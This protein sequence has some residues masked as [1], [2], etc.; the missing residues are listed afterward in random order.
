MV[1]FGI[2]YRRQ[3]ASE[4]IA[5]HNEFDCLEIIVEQFLPLNHSKLREL[6]KLRS[7]FTLIP[8]GL[9][10]SLGS[11]DRPGEKY[12]DA[13]LQILEVIDPPYYSD[14]LAMVSTENHNIGH[15]SPV[16]Y[17]EES[18]E[19]TS[20]NIQEI[21]DLFGIP[22]VIETITQP[23]VLP[24]NTISQEDFIRLICEITKCE[25][26]LDIT[27]LYINSKNLGG[28]PKAFIDR[29]PQASIRQIHLV[30]YSIGTSGRHV[31]SHSKPIQ[32]ELWKLYEYVMSRC[33]PSFVIIERDDDFQGISDIVNDLK[34]ARLYGGSK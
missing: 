28:D 27:N 9:G 14:H 16:W 1:N 20:R 21:Q 22:L 18:L 25:I 5:N 8:H 34:N 32:S 30:G 19:V 23:F 15:L 13:I 4:T 33:S 7:Q 29:L 24:G 12:T 6:E 26:L 31:D 2:G 10:L 3:I 17:T 11:V